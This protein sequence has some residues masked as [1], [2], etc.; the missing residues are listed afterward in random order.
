MA[1]IHLNYA[2]KTAHLGAYSAW[3]GPAVQIPSAPPSVR[4]FSD[5]S[6]NRLKSARVRAFAIIHGPGE[7]PRQPESVESS[8]TYPGAIWL[9][10]WIIAVKAPSFLQ[11]LGRA[12]AKLSF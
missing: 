11:S 5:L 9:G 10:P 4:Q 1:N 7:R 3:W 6:E 2:K 8:K 12:S